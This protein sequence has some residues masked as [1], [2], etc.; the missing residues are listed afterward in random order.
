LLYFREIFALQAQVM[1]NSMRK[2][3]MYNWC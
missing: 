2:N 3:R 1:K